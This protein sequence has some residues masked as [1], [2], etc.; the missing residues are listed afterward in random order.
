MSAVLTQEEIPEKGRKNLFHNLSNK[1]TVFK[2]CFFSLNFF[3]GFFNIVIVF[4]VISIPFPKFTEWIPHLLHKEFERER[5]RHLGER[6]MILNLA[7]NSL[8]K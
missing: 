4:V 3:C 7:E 1:K 2:I 5:I 6:E 8:A